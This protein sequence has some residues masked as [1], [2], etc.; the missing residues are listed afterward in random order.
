M[1]TNTLSI[2]AEQRLC[3]K[4]MTPE[5][6]LQN[7]DLILFLSDWLTNA[8]DNIKARIPRRVW[9]T[10]GFYVIKCYE[11]QK[12]QMSSKQ[13]RR[14]FIH[15]VYTQSVQMVVCLRKRSHN[16]FSPRLCSKVKKYLSPQLLAD[17][18]QWFPKFRSKPKQG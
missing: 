5:V 12:L 13:T 4:T 10:F 6:G 1:Y 8:A 14:C 15:A 3:F 18:A 17:L 7:V 9:K 11:M 16:R 2:E